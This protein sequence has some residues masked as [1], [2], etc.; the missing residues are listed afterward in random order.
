[1]T[2]DLKIRMVPGD[3]ERLRREAE[4]ANLSQAAYVRQRLGMAEPPTRGGAG[5]GQGRKPL[6]LSR[7]AE[8]AEAVEAV[9]GGFSGEMGRF[10]AVSGPMLHRRRNMVQRVDSMAVIL[11]NENLSPSPTFFL[12]DSGPFGPF[13]QQ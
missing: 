13:L 11:R 8:A 10:W 6:K 7:P 4:E 1:M 3:A 5:R 12:T 9:L 2:V